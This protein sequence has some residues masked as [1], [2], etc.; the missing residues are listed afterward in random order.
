ML[1]GER[2]VSRTR[3]ALYVGL[4]LIPL[5]AALWI[6]GLDPGYLLGNYVTSSSAYVTGDLVQVGAPTNGS[7]TRITTNVGD[8]VESGQALAYLIAPPQPGRL[9]VVPSVRAPAPGTIVRMS[10]LQGQ[11]VTQGQTIATIADLQKL[12]VI[13]AVDESSFPNVRIGQSANVYIPALNR[14]FNGKVS[15]LLPDIGAATSRGVGTTTAAAAS[16]ST[17]GMPVRID[18]PYGDALIYPGM[19]AQVTIYVR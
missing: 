7:V 17:T 12:W 8:P 9:P 10:V 16:A 18:F 2:T 15:Q 6:A 19:S 4:C 3:I 5:I 11:N 14:T 1:V 13:A